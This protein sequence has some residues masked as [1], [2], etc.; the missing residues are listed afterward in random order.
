MDINNFLFFARR[1]FFQ[2]MEPGGKTHFTKSFC[3]YLD[4]LGAKALVSPNGL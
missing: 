1:V 3:G 4:N 2:T